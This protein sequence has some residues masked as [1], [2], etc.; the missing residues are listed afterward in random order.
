MEL[1]HESHQNPILLP[2]AEQKFRPKKKCR[3][4]V[5]NSAYS[6][7]FPLDTAGHSG[8]VKCKAG[9]GREYE[10]RLTSLFLTKIVFL[11]YCRSYCYS[12]WFNESCCLYRILHPSQQ[13]KFPNRSP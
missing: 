13:H 4:R 1:V 2:F 9:D 3:L 12:F 11:G 7:E 5:E 6:E 10:V 8:R